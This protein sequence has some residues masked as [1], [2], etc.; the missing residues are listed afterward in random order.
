MILIEARDI[1]MDLGLT[2]SQL[3]FSSRWLG[4][5]P[6]Y[7]SC[8]VA[9]GQKPS[10]EALLALAGR[11]TRKAMQMRRVF[12]HT[13]AT[14]LD[15]LSAKVWNELLSRYAGQPEAA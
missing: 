5:Q 4:K 9:R 1:L 6:S 11:V 13:E 8:V 10:A 15:A 7:M 12:R 14:A 2:D 3:D